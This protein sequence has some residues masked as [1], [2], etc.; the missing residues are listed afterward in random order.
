MPLYGGVEAGGTT[1]VCA[2][3]SGPLELSPRT[4]I[5]TSAPA[6]TLSRVV[7]C[8]RERAAELTAIGV[9]S[10]GPIDRER[11]RI[12]STP[13]SEWV[14]TDV[15]GAIRAA[16][17]SVPVG[18]D[19]DVNAAALAEAR[20]GAAPGLDTFTYVTVGTGIGGGGIVGG[21]LMHGLLHPEMGHMR[22]P[23]HP[24]DTLERGS[25]PFHPDCWEG[26]ASARAIEKRWGADCQ[27]TD[28]TS[29]E[30]LGL[31]AHYLAAGVVNIVCTISPQRLILGGG[32][33]LGGGNVEHRERLLALVRGEVS[34]L[35]GG[36]L[37]LPELAERIDA[38]IV[39]PALGADAGVLGAIV[40]AERAA[41]ADARLAP[42]SIRAK[43]STTGKGGPDEG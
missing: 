30:E 27:A 41:E 20:W 34:R 10:F 1:F 36:Y 43:Q 31:L 17:G 15:V 9:A 18:F 23:R 37:H 16:L 11:G 26:W 13:K 3:G 29:P 7:D 12:T 25:C 42:V 38:Y 21:R 33:I 6:E 40:L 14:D 35:V 19:T 32:V 22:V 5:P 39:A 28:L 4:V 2:V 24:A 8:F